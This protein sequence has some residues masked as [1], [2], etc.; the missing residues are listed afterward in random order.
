MTTLYQ[1]ITVTLN[2]N[3]MS[4]A[5]YKKIIDT[6]KSISVNKLET[7]TYSENVTDRLTDDHRKIL[8]KLSDT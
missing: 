8:K 6:L 4:R 1:D 5:S 2:L 3:E 7:I